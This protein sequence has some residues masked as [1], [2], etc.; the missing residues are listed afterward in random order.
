MH[1]GDNLSVSLEDL[2]EKA[3]AMDKRRLLFLNICDGARFEERGYLPKIGMAPGL[4]SATQATI[5]HLWPVMGYPAAA[6]GAY[7]A[8]NL[9]IGNP[10]FEAYKMA[11]LSIRKPTLDIAEDLTSKIGGELDLIRQLREK[12]ENYASLEF[13][14]SAAFYQ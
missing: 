7:L 8:Y 9:S 3:P 2:W 6:F 13:Y 4:A 12:G 5:S 11:L 10:Y 1:V 14:G